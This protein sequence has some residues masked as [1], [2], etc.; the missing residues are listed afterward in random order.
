MGRTMRT[1]I[2]VGGK[3][4][5]SFYRLGNELLRVGNMVNGISS[6]LISF[7]RESVET[8]TSFE[9][10]MLDT[11]VALRTQY[12]NTSDLERAMD[13]LNDAALKWANNSRFTTADV[14]EGISNAAH[15]GWTLDEILN[16]MPA[17]MN[18]SLA[19][20]MSLAEGLEYL[21]D[22]S[23]AAGV[24]FSQMG[25]LVDYWAYAANSSSTTIPE[26]GQAM[27]KMGATLQFVKGDMAGL[28]TMLAVLADNGTKGTEAGTLL[29]NSMIRLIAPT[30]A[31]AEA[32][33]GLNL[34]AEAL[35]EI[36]AGSAEIEAAGKMLEEAGFSA[37]DS[38]GN[39]KS[40]LDIWKE[41]D[42]ATSGMTEQDRNKVLAA[43]FP[44]RTITGA[45]ALLEAA[46][47]DW[48]GLYD[49]V[50]ENGPG[51][52]DYAAETMES[53]LGGVL[54]HLESTYNVLQT[55]TGSALKDDV[56]SVA[57]AISEMIER[58]NGL[59][60]APFNALVG[61]LEALAVAG[62]ALTVAGSAVKVIGAV[63]SLGFGGKLALAAVG[64]GMAAK[65]IHEW[66][67]AV[68]ESSFGEMGF[69]D[70][71][72]SGYLSGIGADFSAAAAEI[73]KYNGAVSEA[74][75]VYQEKIGELKSG[76]VTAMITDATLT[77]PQKQQ[78]M[79]LGDEIRQS[80]LNG[81]EG[82]YS[83]AMEA[84]AYFAGED[85]PLAAMDEN[86][87][88]AASL[89]ELLTTG[90]DAAIAEAE[91][92]SA[93]LREAM[94][95]AFADGTLT[96]GEM[97]SITAIFDQMT[98]L[99]Q[100]QASAK[101]QTIRQK[102]LDQAQRFGKDNLD[103]AFAQVDQQAAELASAKEDAYYTGL[104]A[105]YTSA[106][107]KGLS[108]AE[109]SAN[110]AEYQKL[111]ASSQMAAYAFAD[112]LKTD[113]ALQGLRSTDGT[114]F[115]A[116]Q[117]AAESLRDGSITQGE[118]K[119]FTRSADIRSFMRFFDEAV[120]GLGGV[121]AMEEKIAQYRSAGY[122]DEA[123]NL[124]GLLQLYSFANAAKYSEMHSFGLSAT[125]E[126][127]NVKQFADISEAGTAALN[128]LAAGNIGGF[129][130]AAMADENFYN[131]FYS[132]MGRLQSSY[133]FET[134]GLA[135]KPELA[136]WQ[137]MFG[138]GDPE[139]Y[140][141]VWFG[142]GDES[143]GLNQ[144]QTLAVTPEIDPGPLEA[145][146]NAQYVVD[147]L[148]RQ[149]GMGLSELEQQGVQVSVDGDTTSLEATIDAEDGQNLMAY[150]DGDVTQLRYQILSQDGEV[151]TEVVNGDITALAAAIEQY[152]G[153]IITVKVNY[154]STGLSGPAAQQYAE[155][156]RATQASIFGEAGPEWAIP[157]A[158]S[159]R[160]AEL[161]NAA[162]EASGFTWP[163]LMSRNGGL[164]S[165]GGSW[166]LV[167]SPTIVAQ[168]ATGVAEKLKDDKRML[169]AYLRRRQ[170][171]EE[172]EVYA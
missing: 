95:S 125:E 159:Q 110:V 21:V 71:M 76:L 98:K 25:D 14:A 137:L 160:T 163:E 92:L 127:I 49:A 79:A 136:A 119:A 161:L 23:N 3:A 104:E 11:K 7:G 73:E 100:A 167:Y 140:R 42:T 29:R 165:G 122:A 12:E 78:Y 58:V 158:H 37:Y 93:Q 91:T 85:S 81:I 26:M 149:E 155:G 55:R 59:D 121:K 34:D 99:A 54:R 64:I 38:R 151:L 133:D 32:M 135:G 143:Y 17:A 130:T 89:M 80:V 115:D 102:M 138:E 41:L 72:L 67:D 145:M 106:E 150:I 53:G 146:E 46:K 108:A 166:T 157:E 105:I 82:H 128:A 117:Q 114:A 51:Y 24:E 10:Y 148:P 84:V 168:D 8:Y 48:N 66:N 22:I 33:D 101:E 86:N 142:D 70:T 123:S 164:N 116:L 87:T 141:R 107:Y 134:M 63:A 36:Y 170:L 132:A 109:T 40:F 152:N 154:V 126:G 61:G 6:K 43:I 20:S 4:D 169:E 112:N 153:K 65:A 30:Q 124:S 56:S 156:G 2:V 69:D 35:D 52:A 113:I 9:D 57:G 83:A 47:N 5:S 50:R 162:R 19:G 77:E 62:P 129:Q 172:T 68:Y 39:L 131:A 75:D 45:L 60:E 31:A 18:V 120:D 16:G 94:T 27:Q 139:Q 13:T 15:A 28:T 88:V 74:L 97:D 147:I 111:Y 171:K 96:Q 44:T 1:D 90:Y 103:A 144:E 118:I